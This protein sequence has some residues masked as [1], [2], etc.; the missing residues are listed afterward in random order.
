MNKKL[1]IAIVG[2]GPVGMI[3]AVKFK[4][5]GCDV[6]LCVRNKIKLNQI[7]SE[8]IRL[9]GKMESTTYFEKIYASVEEMAS[10]KMDLDY[11]IFSLKSYQIEKAA[12][13]ALKM[14]SDKLRVISAQNGIDVEKLLIPI[15]GSNKILR[16]VINYAGNLTAPN[17]VNVTFFT[18][19]NYLGS[20]DD[21]S[22]E[23][24]KE[25]AT[26]LTEVDLHTDVVD[27]FELLKRTWEKTILNSSLSALCGVG[28]LTMAE[29]MADADTV[30]LIEQIINE[31][32]VVAHA[33]KIIFPDDF[34]RKC[35]RYLTKG[36]NHFPSLA[37]DVINNRQTEIDY[38]NGK[39]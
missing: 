33:E 37:G 17:V 21:N 30:E 7:K 15:F 31:A 39:I 22:A 35:M 2:L 29:A 4:E 19:P 10:E 8:G 9:E 28:R 36:G 27:S 26:I 34:I 6:S 14:D 20:I 25:I 13:Q 32:V 12:Q 18:P 5:A 38:F 24:A 11:L 1:K 3:M 23:Q 16:M